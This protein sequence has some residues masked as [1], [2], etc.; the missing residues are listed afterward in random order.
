MV[1]LTKIQYIQEIKQKGN[2]LLKIQFKMRIPMFS[3]VPHNLS[4]NIIPKTTRLDFVSFI[5]TIS[6]T[7]ITAYIVRSLIAK[8][9]LTLTKPS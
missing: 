6:T 9:K 3:K 1:L 4:K 7:V 2:A 5:P 8:E